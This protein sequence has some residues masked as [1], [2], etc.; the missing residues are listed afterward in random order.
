MKLLIFATNA[1]SIARQK[2]CVGLHFPT[3][4]S[5]HFFVLFISITTKHFYRETALK[6]SDS[7][8]T[9]QEQWLFVRLT[10][11]KWKINEFMITHKK[12][13]SKNTKLIN[14]RQPVFFEIVQHQHKR[15]IQLIFVSGRTQTYTSRSVYF[16]TIQYVFNIFQ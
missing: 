13:N 15:Q 14:Y 12:F 16:N 1:F 6:I 8:E 11:A 9:V 3:L 5:F 4:F 10:C 7:I 2:W